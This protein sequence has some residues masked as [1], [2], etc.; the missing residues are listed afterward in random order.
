MLAKTLVP[1]MPRAIRIPISLVRRDTV[2]AER[3]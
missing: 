2:Y 3:P 1:A